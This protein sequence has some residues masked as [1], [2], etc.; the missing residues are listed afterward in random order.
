MRCS[1]RRIFSES[2]ASVSWS[3]TGTAA[4][5]RMGPA[6]RFSST[7]CTVQ[8]ANLAPYSR[9]CFFED[10]H[11]L[12]VVG[13]AFQTLGRDYFGGDVARFGAVDAW[14]AFAIADDDGDFRVGNTARGDAVGQ[15][16]EVG[17]ASAEQDADAFSHAGRKLAYLMPGA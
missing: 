2:D 11:Y 8:P 16:F 13:F 1:S 3:S 5:R 10:F 4:C 12:A 17:T 6:S 9:V 7:K 14:R 15:G